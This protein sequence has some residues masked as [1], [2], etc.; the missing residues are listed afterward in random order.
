LSNREK[1]AVLLVALGPD[2]T[3]K[4]FK[5]LREDDIESLTLD[6]ARLGRVT[7]EIRR[8][9]VAEFHEMCLAQEVISEGGIDQARRALET[10]FGQDKANEVINK[11]IQALQVLPFDF[12][13]KTDPSQLLSFIQDEHP[14]TIALILA[15]LNANQA[16][17]VLSGLPQELRAEVARRIAIMDRT[18]PEVIRE[19]EK[20]LERKLSN[21][22]VTQGFTTAGGV[23]SLVEVLNWVDR[24]TEKTILESLTETTLRFRRC[25]ARWIRRNWRWP[26]RA[27]ARKSRRASSRT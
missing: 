16:A 7:P 22:V 20:V 9:V 3:A 21:A 23:K 5:H 1:A 10:A 24:T 18:P 12:I 4:I 25:C 11:V 19:I 17:A 8:Q 26:S 13:K 27:S 6:V 2:P 15:H 14:Q